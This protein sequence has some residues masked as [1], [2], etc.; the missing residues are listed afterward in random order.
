MQDSI[1]LFNEKVANVQRGG[2]GSGRW[3]R[4]F[5][6]GK[7]MVQ[8]IYQA[9]IIIQHSQGLLYIIRRKIQWW[10]IKWNLPR[11]SVAN[12]FSHMSLSTYLLMH[13][14][15]LHLTQLDK[16]LSDNEF[17]SF[18]ITGKIHFQKDDILVSNN[19]SCLKGFH[20]WVPKDSN[21]AALNLIILF[22]IDKRQFEC[23]T[24]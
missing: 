6:C 22:S 12:L 19:M 4:P 5:D 10:W 15:F 18:F 3:L 20:H 1:V 13:Q 17:L 24:N 16:T 23:H 2:G 8:K 11:E 14:T 7:M 9:S 21:V